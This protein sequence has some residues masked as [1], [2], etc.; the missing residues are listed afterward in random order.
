MIKFD[1]GDK[2]RINWTSNSFEKENY[3]W[4][5][6][7]FKVS[8]VLETKPVTYRLRDLKDDETLGGFYD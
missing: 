4:S 7:F 8:K 2:V 5:T 6:Q 1:V 3:W